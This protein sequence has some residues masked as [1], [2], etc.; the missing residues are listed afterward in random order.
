[1]N[2]DMSDDGAASSQVDELRFVM[3]GSKRGLG[4]LSGFALV[5]ALCEAFFLAALVQSIAAL[6]RQSANVV[7][8]PGS[9][10]VDV[11]VRLLLSLALVAALVRAAATAAAALLGPRLAAQARERLRRQLFS[12]YLEADW[13]TQSSD[14]SGRL[15]QTLS[16]SV[17]DATG[18][19]V[20]L[21]QAVPAGLT[22]L[23]L[24]IVSLF[25]NP[26]VTSVLIVLGGLIAAAMRP[27]SSRAHRAAR[28]DAAARNATASHVSG[29]LAAGAEISVLGARQGV[30]DVGLHRIGQAERSFARAQGFKR[31]VSTAGQSIAFVLAALAITAL[32]FSD[33]SV[34]FAAVGTIAVLLL[35]GAGLAQQ[36]QSATSQVGTM[37]PFIEQIRTLLQSYQSRRQVFGTEPFPDTATI[38]LR[39]AAYTYPGSAAPAVTV[40]HATMEHGRSTAIIG[41]SGSGKSTLIQLIL[42]LRAPTEGSV[43]IGGV[44]AESI[45]EA[46]FSR[47]V[48]YVPQAPHLIPGTIF[49]N[50]SFF[51]SHISQGEV[52]AAARLAHLH[53]EIEQMKDGYETELDS[54]VDALSGGQKQRLALARALAGSPKVLVLDEPTSALDQA[55]EAAVMDTLRQLRGESTVVMIT[56]RPSA[57]GMCDAV[58]RVDSGVLGEVHPDLP[59]RGEVAG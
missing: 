27:L 24:L 18:V 4:V 55:N 47:C 49:E 52:V 11:D 14:K 13:A 38:S 48:A 59:A 30:L 33:W 58:F 8:G 34:D 10:S 28:G 9:W 1:M 25:I 5:A 44:S 19:I 57:A 40:A 22:L 46:E 2:V 29:V 31:V 32:A 50:I 56:H 35:R 51:R 45:N 6:S 12:A 7:L 17:N 3:R 42:R 23:V 15:L 26:L 16:T 21:T 43:M 54:H 41:P 37:A 20:V 39:N 36:V 53:D